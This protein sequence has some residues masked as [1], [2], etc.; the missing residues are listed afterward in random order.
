MFEAISKEATCDPARRFCQTLFWP[1]SG[2]R[3]GC[4]GDPPLPC[5]EV[6][7][8]LMLGSLA[9][10]RSNVRGAYGRSAWILARQCLVEGNGVREHR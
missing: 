7:C 1:E 2:C 6:D 5:H 3:F 10:R 8:M 4:S 9:K